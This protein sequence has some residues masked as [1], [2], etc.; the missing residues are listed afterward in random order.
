MTFLPTL[1][2]EKNISSVESH[3]QCVRMVLIITHTENYS[4]KLKKSISEIGIANS[5]KTRLPDYL[6]DALESLASFSHCGLTSQ[7]H[8]Y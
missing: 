4:G 7:V 1:P 6:I 2:L 3:A 8:S 5:G